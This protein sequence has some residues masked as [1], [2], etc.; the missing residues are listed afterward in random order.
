MYASGG[1]NGKSPIF[2]LRCVSLFLITFLSHCH[3][4]ILLFCSGTYCTYM[5][6]VG[7]LFILQM[8]SSVFFLSRCSPCGCQVK[9]CKLLFP[10][11]YFV[12][13]GLVLD[14]SF[15]HS[16]TFEELFA[17]YG[18]VYKI[19]INKHHLCMIAGLLLEQIF[20]HNFIL[21]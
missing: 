7:S 2:L 6:C 18:P 8:V 9:L 11:L 14:I 16:V 17:I 20:Q 4:I 21:N 1:Q 5:S 19:I 10:F 13:I 12:F 15:I 3:A